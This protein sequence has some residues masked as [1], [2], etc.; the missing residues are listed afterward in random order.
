MTSSM[1]LRMCFGSK[2]PYYIRLLSNTQFLPSHLFIRSD[3]PRSDHIDKQPE[4]VSS[5][6]SLLAD[7]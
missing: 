7:F 4:E 3:H 1:D 6:T 2:I 5:A